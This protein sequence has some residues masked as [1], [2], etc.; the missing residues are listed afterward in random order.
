MANSLASSCGGSS[1]RRSAISSRPR[2]HCEPSTTSQ[3]KVRTTLLSSSGKIAR[4]SSRPTQRELLRASM[5]AIGK[6][7]S[8]HSPVTTRPIQTVRQRMAS[9]NGSVK[10]LPNAA[11]TSA[12]PERRGKNSMV[13]AGTINPMT[14]TTR[15]GIRSRLARDLITLPSWV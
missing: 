1:T 12:G 7:I 5:E 3:P 13:T 2:T 9:M 15:P 4:A 11:N 10:K 14:R 8:T 6:P